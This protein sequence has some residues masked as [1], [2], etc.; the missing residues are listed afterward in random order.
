MLEKARS[1]LGSKHNK[2]LIERIGAFK[3]GC[4]E[5]NNLAIIVNKTKT[6]MY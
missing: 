5:I 2:Y 4:V 6:N 1:L 3:L